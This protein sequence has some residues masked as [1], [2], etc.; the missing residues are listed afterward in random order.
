MKI[1]H[2]GHQ[3]QHGNL[4]SVPCLLALVIFWGAWMGSPPFKFLI[5][6]SLIVLG[7]RHTNSISVSG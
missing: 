1:L 3:I 7:F 6:R 4:V 5:G 2:L